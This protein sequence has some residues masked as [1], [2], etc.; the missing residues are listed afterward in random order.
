MD[1]ASTSRPSSGRTSA[2]C[3]SDPSVPSQRCQ[4]RLTTLTQADVDAGTSLAEACQIL[5]DTYLSRRRTW[6]S[7]GDY[8]RRMLSGAVS[9]G[10]PFPMDAPISTS[11]TCMLWLHDSEEGSAHVVASWS[12]LGRHP[13][14][15]T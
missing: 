1:C 5:Q 12:S 14:S 6:A 8:D 15:G 9:R 10:V 7:F 4:H 11:R 13:S 2:A 3:S